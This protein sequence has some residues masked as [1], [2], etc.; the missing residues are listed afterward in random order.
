M[1]EIRREHIEKLYKNCLIKDVRFYQTEYYDKYLYTMRMEVSVEDKIISLVFK[2]RGLETIKKNAYAYKNG[3]IQR[4]D[5]CKYTVEFE[6][7]YFIRD[8]KT[9]SLS[10]D[11]N[12]EF[13]RCNKYPIWAAV[14]YNDG[15]EPISGNSPSEQIEFLFKKNILIKPVNGR[16]PDKIPPIKS[17]YHTRELLSNELLE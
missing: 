7:E 9:G 16:L 5:V 8:F 2:I 3:G 17:P 4:I 14:Y 12:G 6:S 15:Y 11:K 13:V 1:P 10:K